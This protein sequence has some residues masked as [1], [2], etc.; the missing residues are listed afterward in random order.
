MCGVRG[1][2]VDMVVPLSIESVYKHH[3]KT[4]LITLIWC[5]GFCP[6]RMQH[7][8]LDYGAGGG[9]TGGGKQPSPAEEEEE[10]FYKLRPANKTDYLCQSWQ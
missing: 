8:H 3:C 4:T 5:S 6:A 10:E 2:M 9:W 1:G 7:T